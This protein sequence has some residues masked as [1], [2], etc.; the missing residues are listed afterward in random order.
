MKVE[1]FDPA[2]NREQRRWLERRLGFDPG[3]LD[4]KPLPPLPDHPLIRLMARKKGPT[5]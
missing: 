1:L 3:D 4:E 5:P 2:R